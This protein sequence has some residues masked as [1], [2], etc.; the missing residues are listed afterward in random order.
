MQVIGL[1]KKL[2]VLADESRTIR[3]P[4]RVHELLGR[5]KRTISRLEQNNGRQSTRQEL[6]QTMGMT[7]EEID[8]LL[9]YL[10]R[11]VTSL[12]IPVKTKEGSVPLGEL[13]K[14]DDSIKPPDEIVANEA[15]KPE[16]D[17]VLKSSLSPREERVLKARFGWDGR[18][19][20]LEEAGRE[21]GLTRERARQIEKE[22]LNKLKELREAGELNDLEVYLKY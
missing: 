8:E 11:Q 10:D 17:K 1:R 21:F 13:L 5:L 6:A 7:L 4:V 14:K 3:L 16:M 15:L 22:A 9:I 18:P 19:K 12:D 20:T 2:N